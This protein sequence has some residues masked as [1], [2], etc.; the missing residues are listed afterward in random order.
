MASAPVASALDARTQAF[1]ALTAAQ[2]E[3]IQRFGKVPQVTAGE[4][5]FEAGEIIWDSRPASQEWS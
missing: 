3:R 2:I 5:L 4:T 1:P